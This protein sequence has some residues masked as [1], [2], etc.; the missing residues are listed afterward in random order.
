MQAEND[1]A[2]STLDVSFAPGGDASAGAGGAAS[3]ANPGG[4]QDEKPAEVIEL[5][6]TARQFSARLLPSRRCDDNTLFASHSPSYSLHAA[7][8]LG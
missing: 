6:E 7:T 5:E 4:A 8:G 3:A 2:S 1:E